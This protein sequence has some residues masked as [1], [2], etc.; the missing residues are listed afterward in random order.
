[1]AYDSDTGFS[2][3]PCPDGFSGNGTMCDSDIKCRDEPCFPGRL[4]SSI[5]FHISN[6][7]YVVLL[8]KS[9]LQYL[10]PVFPLSSL[11]CSVGVECTDTI[12]GPV[13]GVCPDG[14]TGDGTKN[15][16]TETCALDPCF[17]DVTCSD[18]VTGPECGPCPAGFEGDGIECLDI[19]E[20]GNIP[21]IFTVLIILLALICV[22]CLLNYPTICLTY[23]Y[24]I[25]LMGITAYVYNSGCCL[26]FT[27]CDGRAVR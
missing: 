21:P 15:N 6:I 18:T 10:E 25:M 20:V 4:Y 13:C 2:C 1:M 26:L 3:G 8:R 14:Y 22:C 16:C 5:C 27:V 7:Y 19:D 23:R 11:L 24:V 17:T 12:M 9:S